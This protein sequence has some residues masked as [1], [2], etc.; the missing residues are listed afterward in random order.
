MRNHT[1][2]RLTSTESGLEKP[3]SWIPSLP[4][5]VEVAPQRRNDSNLKLASAAAACT[6]PCTCLVDSVADGWRFNPTTMCPL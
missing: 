1:D 3:G 2:A 6:D 4:A 5:L